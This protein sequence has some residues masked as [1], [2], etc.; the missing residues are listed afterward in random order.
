MLGALRC[1]ANG[2][3][4]IILTILSR[5][6]DRNGNFISALEKTVDNDGQVDEH[7]NTSFPLRLLVR[8]TKHQVTARN[9]SVDI[10]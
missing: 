9:G 3:N 7:G 8:T 2:R 1:G 6:F 10:Q 4:N 5:L